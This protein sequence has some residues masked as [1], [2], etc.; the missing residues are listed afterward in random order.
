[1]YFE[2]IV[3]Q[4]GNILI[5]DLYDNGFIWVDIGYGCCEY[6]GVFLFNQVGVLVGFVSMFIDLV[7][8]LVFMDFVFDKVIIDLYVQVVDV[9]VFG[10]W[11]EIG[12]FDLSI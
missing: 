8:L 10:Y 12:V 2:L 9:V 4:V 5:F 6:V 3:V 1:M 7:C 11:E